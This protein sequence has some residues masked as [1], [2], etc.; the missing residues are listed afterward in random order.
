MFAIHRGRH[1]TLR[2]TLRSTLHWNLHCNL[3]CN[4]RNALVVGLLVCAPLAPLPGQTS[5]EPPDPGSLQRFRELYVP[6][7]EFK[8]Y[9]SKDPTGVIMDLQEYRALVR[10]VFEREPLPPAPPLPPIETGIISASYR[11]TLS[12]K[13]VRLR[14]TLKIRVSRS[15]WV[16]C[17]LGP[18]VPGM[19]RAIMD[20]EPAWIVIDS[21]AIVSGR[22]VSGTSKG[23]RP[24]KTGKQNRSHPHE[25]AFLFVRGLGEHTLEITYS[26]PAF[27]RR[28]HWT[29]GGR[30]IKAASARL[31]LDVPGR[32]LA[33]S[34][35][36]TLTTESIEDRTRLVLAL[37][38]AAE[39]SIHWQRRQAETENQAL[40][41]AE[42][43]ITV[44]PRQENPRFV[45]HCDASVFRREV[46][47]LLFTPPPQSTVLHVRGALLKSWEQVENGI[48]VFLK[49]ATQGKIQLEFAGI[50]TDTGGRFTLSPPALDGAFSNRGYLGIIAPPT[51]RVELESVNGM[52]ELPPRELAMPVPGDDVSVMSASGTNA[53]AVQRLFSFSSPSASLTVQS[54]G[55]VPKTESHGTYLLQVT[56]DAVRLDGIIRLHVREG[57]VYQATLRL[58]DPWT[59]RVLEER[60][61]SGPE[62]GVSY[63][64]I[65]AQANRRLVL[66]FERGIERGQQVELRLGFDHGTFATDTPW[67]RR[68]LSLP[69]PAL[70]G[71]ERGRTDLGVIL[72][73]SMDTLT[74]DLPGWR[75]LTA[76]ET[77]QLGL[78]QGLLTPE[79]LAGREIVAGMT[80]RAAEPNATFTLVHR[81][82]RGEYQV[83]THVLALE[84]ALRVRSDIR[85]VVVDR[86]IEE[87]ALR[88][89]GE[90]GS[91]TVILGA[92]IREVDLNETTGLRTIRFR[93]PWLGTR[94][95]RI[96]YEAT[97]PPDEAGAL[98]GAELDDDF[99]KERFLVLQSRGA[100]E[101]DATPGPG[102]ES[103]AL[104]D[105]PEFSV[106]WA[107][108][109]LLEAYRYRLQGN[110][111]TL[112]TL[113]HPRAPIVAR[114]A[115]EMALT[116][117]IGREGISRTE[118]EILLGS[119]QAQYLEIGLPIDARVLAVRVGDRSLRALRPARATADRN[120]ISVPLPPRSYS[121]I[122][123]T[124]ERPAVDSPTSPARARDVGSWGT[125]TWVERGPQ[126]IGTPVGK[127]T[128]RIYHPGG[129][130]FV[131]TDGNLVVTRDTSWRDAPG[132]FWESFL[133]PLLSGGTPRLTFGETPLITP[134]QA[135]RIPPMS[136]E[137][138]TLQTASLPQGRLNARRTA[139]EAVTNEAPVSSMILEGHLIEAEKIGGNPRITIAYWSHR[140][141]T[142][143]RR[144]VVGLTILGAVVLLRLISGFRRRALI[145]AYAFGFATFLPLA[146]GWRS[147]LLMVPICEGLLLV[148]LWGSAAWLVRQGYS[149][150]G[151][152]RNSRTARTRRAAVRTTSPASWFV[153]GAL[154]LLH[155][156]GIVGGVAR[157]QSQAMV[158]RETKSDWDG[159]LIPYEVGQEGTPEDVKVYVPRGKFTELWRA[160][161]DE[162]K[163]AEETPPA[164]YFTGSA[165]YDLHVDGD[166]TRI[167]G[168]IPVEILTDDW[169]AL[170]LEFR[171]LRIVSLA[172]DG[173]VAGIY[174]EN[175]VTHVPLQGR[176]K[177]LLSV[178]LVGS[179]K[180]D[181]GA[182]RVRCGLGVIRAASLTA[183]LPLGA[184]ITLRGA[185]HP[186][187]LENGE[188][189]TRLIA[190][191]GGVTE[192]EI[193]WSFPKLERETGSRL[194][195]ISYT[196]LEPTLDGVRVSRHER[197]QVTG[198]PVES[199]EYTVHGDWSIAEVIGDGIS[200]WNVARAAEAPGGANAT[201]TLRVFFGT[202]VKR[203]DFSIRGHASVDG[204][205]PL[206]TLSLTDSTRQETYVGLNHS[207][208]RR[209]LTGSVTGMSRVSGR[210]LQRHFKLNDAAPDRL[211]QAYSSGAGEVVQ[212]G[213]VGGETV[214][215][216]EAVAVVY[217]DRLVVFGR[218]RYNTAHPGVIRYE[219]PL[220]QNWWIRSV[221]SAGLR[222]W[223]VL[224][225]ENEKRLVAHWSGGAKNG[226]EI[227]WVA[228]ERFD[229]SP[230]RLALPALR[231]ASAGGTG[232][233]RETVEWTFAAAREYDLSALES[234]RWESVPLQQAAPDLE[235]AP[236]VSY[237][238]AYRSRRSDATLVVGVT[239]KTS[240]LSATTVS[241]VRVAEDYLYVNTRLIYRVRFAGR[242]RFRFRL[243]Q[244]AELVSLD[245]RNQQARSVQGT[246]IEIVLQSPL[247]GEHTVDLAYRILRG[248]EG[249]PRITPITLFDG[250]TV[251]EAV[252]AY[253]GVLQ[254]GKAILTE[255]SVSGL[256]PLEAEQ[257]P[258]VPQGVAS[259]NLEP[260]YRATALDWSLSLEE[261]EIEE[262]AGVAA[263]AK[264]AEI[265]TVIAGD[266]TTRTEALYTLHNRT[267]QFLH[268]E[269]PPGARLWCVTLDGKPVAVG[270]RDDTNTEDGMTIEVPV[271]YVG[272]AHLDLEIGLRYEEPRLSLGGLLSRSVELRA[273]RVRNV[274]VLETLWTVRYPQGFEVWQSGGNMRRVTASAGYAKKVENLLEQQGKIIKIARDSQS[275]RLRAQARKELARLE[276]ELGDN[277][278][279]LEESY[280]S[281]AS[282]D[283]TQTPNQQD[284][285]QQ[286][287]RQGQLIR[288]AQK[289]QVDNR[290][291]R[292]DE[293]GGQRAA[294]RSQVEQAFRDNAYFLQRGNWRGGRK[295]SG[296]SKDEAPVVPPTPPDL[297]DEAPFGGLR[298]LSMKQLVESEVH[299]QE[300]E[301]VAKGGLPAL[302]R[303]ASLGALP[304]L[305]APPEEIGG[306]IKLAFQRGGGDATIV[307]S[308][309][310]EGSVARLTALVLIVFAIGLPLATML[311]A[312]RKRRQGA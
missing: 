102:L 260:A 109:R 86:A 295:N 232:T 25:R 90:A 242:D 251:L 100:V 154:T 293:S 219:L 178:E 111:G 146:L 255:A 120:I 177:K 253:V 269:L 125:A 291:L 64:E 34:P 35:T 216:T 68:D 29:L 259:R 203:A 258:F 50:F 14:A 153:L 305:E 156:G 162:P 75:S 127:T 144:G 98:P 124:Y 246:E 118:V 161:N 249:Q 208:R 230:T 236:G 61:R 117:I 81:E 107:E 287:A 311:L 93:R 172:I 43:R 270:Q 10:K 150:T 280:Q 21:G 160:A 3:H 277:L 40:I 87:L 296:D 17:D 105:I 187:V 46:E 66:N 312:R 67:D 38:S 89:P 181:L 37:G 76:Q 32:A 257:I 185:R 129:Y 9:A 71:I 215:T 224:T 218:S 233:V 115:Q 166:R 204:Q 207:Q 41:S 294:E 47:S 88:L 222:F 163:L 147:P 136:I 285:P 188:D 138:T 137:A 4:L 214:L 210:E 128:W 101:V 306:G 209:F 165:E 2:S 60:V 49:E 70:L 23:S 5:G 229:A 122:H 268:L 142:A 51:Q 217:S 279:E 212:L 206:P 114:L 244:G 149:W 262:T 110:P 290:A 226:T 77:E 78:T 261:Q 57:K 211:Y 297:A 62:H 252:D 202:P 8:R 39:F 196:G 303:A 148:G 126:L 273:P 27:E 176:G 191:L 59:L 300:E 28:D 133:L 79:F 274:E 74:A 134:P 256:S 52:I 284:A 205:A 82:S 33:S 201:L 310:R 11:G 139:P 73:A 238:F 179:V 145:F 113:V 247:T 231:I 220:P 304:G 241:F 140:W 213:P 223:E 48:R 276:Q 225:T 283:R 302:K 182:F 19:G 227:T 96:E 292:D 184:L 7:D 84:T 65:G 288:Q 186:G 278:A 121:R 99:G 183:H 200:E 95:F 108:G 243:P 80:T 151:R 13:T 272:S 245:T 282:A 54:T 192:F 298:G 12:G 36:G 15:G 158:P 130:R 72:P 234:G 197:V 198:R 195:S 45:W 180:S 63:E 239:P 1:G 167:I 143:A 6:Y 190:D 85:L 116:T 123:V 193:M 20:G 307:L 264:L 250:G 289:A 55:Y 170:P 26:L 24:R 299:A 92:G 169:V 56:S 174:V 194:E 221:K 103:I 301:L 157:A 104:D 132:N 254:S 309:R 135:P 141:E 131:P 16:R 155:A 112:R 275:R 235:L 69:V 266:G 248:V 152:H 94:H 42:H 106:A 228:E 189:E 53:H 286:R 22:L 18:P 237:R 97:R 240:R 44:S 31:T 164:P 199:L 159:V 263:V 30:L 91:N 119:P 281:E 58:P 308:G 171:H 175:G 265:T 267:L 271:E 168:R 173:E 83:V